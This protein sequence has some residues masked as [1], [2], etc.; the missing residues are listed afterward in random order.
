[1]NKK[2]H[3][4]TEFIKKVFLIAFLAFLTVT[5]F[6]ESKNSD[7]WDNKKPLDDSSGHFAVG[8]SEPCNSE[9][10]A[11]SQAWRFVLSYFAN[12]ISTSVSI[13]IDSYTTEEGFEGSALDAYSLTIEHSTWKSDVPLYGVTILDKKIERDSDGKII[14]KLL[15]FI[16]VEN[17]EKSKTAVQD[18]ETS[19]LVYSY[20]K[21]HSEQSDFPETNSKYT[22]WV[23]KNCAVFEISDETDGEAFVRWL[24]VY[25]SK[26]FRNIKIYRC[27]FDALPSIIV[28]NHPDYLSLCLS[29]LESIGIFNIER[30][31]STALISGKSKKS[32]ASFSDYCSSIKDS[33]KITVFGDNQT[34]ITKF[35]NFAQKNFSFSAVSTTLSFTSFDDM[36]EYVKNHKKDLPSRYFA[37]CCSETSEESWGSKSWVNATV[38]FELYD[39][40]TDKNLSSKEAVSMPMSAAQPKAAIEN[41]CNPDKNPES[42]LLVMQELFN[43]LP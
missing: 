6:A 37:F 22:Q 1:M 32:L 39:L 34:V 21:E 12:S 31:G 40:E 18:E 24:E 8:I 29:S 14:V 9:K 5:L 3:L 10:E 42:L 2:I 43:N 19:A 36:K 4:Y 25:F 17:F 28:Y 13:N 23:K 33:K 20:F 15:G 35:K 38:W 16:S 30:K 7:N 11:H 27:S 41:A 26:L